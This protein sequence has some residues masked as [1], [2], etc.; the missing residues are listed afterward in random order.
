MHRLIL[1]A[2][3]LAASLPA[4]DSLEQR[5]RQH[6]IDLLKIDTSNPPGNETRA[7]EYLKRVTDAAGIPSEL[8]GKDPARL[9]FVARLRG[10]GSKRP[11]LLMA[12]TD[13]VPV[14]R[15]QWTVDPFTALLKDGYLYGRGAQDDKCFLAA[16]LAVFVELKRRNVSLDRDVI[17]L[18]ESGEEGSSDVGIVWMMQYAYE[19]IDAEFALNEGG[20]AMDTPSGL[21]VFHIQTTE[22]VPTR[23]VLQA[24]G[25][26]GH[27]SL[28]RPDNPV[29]RVARAVTRLGDTEQPVRLNETT[30]RYF[31]ALAATPDYRWLTELL[32]RLEN[33]ATAMLTAS[34]I[35]ARDP[36]LDASLRTTISPTVFHAGLRVNVIPNAGE[37]QL[38]VRRLPNETAE[39]VLA[40]FRAIIGD[41]G[42]Q[43]SPAGLNRPASEP[44]S[45]TTALYQAMERVFSKAHPKALVAPYMQ[46][47]STD[48]ANLRTKG[49]AVYGVPL[50]EENDK[51]LHGNDERIGVANFEKGSRLLWDVV[52]DVAA[53]H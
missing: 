30:R 3:L 52:L 40:R 22:K 50:F 29:L 19:K 33:P 13:V 23:I 9:N 37:A 6:L 34:E 25:T 39:E 21:R 24:R 51:R 44:S 27:G 53:R 38:D 26:A 41:D 20:Y 49:M 4:Q 35:R 18:A 43:I 5:A 42:V 12:H 32:P 15:D 16:E 31:R 48:G 36:E 45:L 17:F 11:L 1:T 28:P 8:L 47:G 10:A 14:E 7:A 46:R 2:L